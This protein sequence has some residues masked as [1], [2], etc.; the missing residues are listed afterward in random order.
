MQ[1]KGNF[2]K[3]IF[4]SD[5]GYQ[6][7][8]FKVRELDDDNYKE[9]LNK[10]I[11]FTGYFPELNENDYYVFNGSFKEHERYGSQF[12]VVSYE[13][14]R[15]TGKDAVIDF[16]S[17]D[18][19]KGIGEKKAIKIVEVLGDD[20]LTVIIENPNN[21]MLVPGIT[22]KQK[23]I[24]YNNL[25]KYQA[26]YKV[27]LYL[28]EIG[29]NTKDALTIFYQY[30]ENTQNV[31]LEN[32]YCLVDDINEISFRK[33]DSFRN[34]LGIELTDARRINSGI[35]YVFNEIAAT[36]GDIY[37]FKDELINYTMRALN[38]MDY[39][40][41]EECLI[42]LITKG[43]IVNKEEKY[44]LKKY[45]LE[46]L[47]VSKRLINLTRMVGLKIDTNYFEALEKTF[48]IKF[49]NDQ[50]DAIIKSLEE[51]F[52]IITGGPGTGKTTIIKAIVELY[53]AIFGLNYEALSKEIAL[54]AP[55]GRASK[56]I[57]ES[58]T[59]PAYTIH[60]F[61]KW[62]K[63][64]NTFGVNSENKSEVKM[65]I[66]DESSMIDLSLFHSL[67]QGLNEGTRIILVGDYDQLPSVGCGQV[68][69][70]LI[71]S[72]CFVIVK[73][74]E[75][76]RQAK[77]SNIIK[78]AYDINNQTLDEDILFYKDDLTFI[79]ADNNNLKDKLFDVVK[80]YTY[81]DYNRFQILAPI[82]AYDNG[83]DDLNV[84]LQSVIN[85]KNDNNS[86]I[87]GEQVYRK[88]DKIIQ[89][90]NMPDENIFN[91]D[92]GIIEEI[93]TVPKEIYVNYDGN[94]VKYTPS[95]FD[96][97]KHGFCISIH[98][99][100]GSE[101]DTVIIPILNKYN[102]MLYKKLIY[103]AVTRAKTKLYLIGE[104]SALKQAINND[105][106][107]ERKTTL[108]KFIIDGINN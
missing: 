103:T 38:I 41:I 21:L 79:E 98:K 102:K 106:Y 11:T 71:E 107:K 74:K 9:H 16:L 32:I 1:I 42:N 24:I 100:Q 56:R 54:L 77:E 78:L 43:E 31:V 33:I 70:D 45:Y 5:K 105:S 35:K 30:H 65:V 96:K 83:I 63:E 81:N 75:L 34:N 15:P 10:T 94:V 85:P 91:G 90:V 80:D 2:R 36:K 92:I 26:S 25:V 66:V 46:E 13:V 12:N 93:S 73:L 29:F 57:S 108:K 37:L 8:L 40:L 76:Y 6:V 69:K 82:Y 88:Y 87:V 67:L 55:T 39:D 58:T 17:S 49:N 14:I 44:Y 52:L 50:K 19:F 61:L 99:S 47:Y 86:I 89:L 18:L 53:S 22:E 101:F 59:L 97:I 60:R 48:D 62:D 51:Q 7:G 23:E 20:A 64:S 104:V 28:T 84:F 3:T 68:L 4:K 72:D 95:M 27:I